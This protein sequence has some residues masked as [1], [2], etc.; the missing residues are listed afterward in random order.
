M[1]DLKADNLN[2]LKNFMKV[3]KQFTEYIKAG[4]D[5]KDLSLQKFMN[6]NTDLFEEIGIKKEVIDESLEKKVKDPKSE[7]RAPTIDD[8]SGVGL[9]EPVS[10]SEPGTAS[11]LAE[12]GT[13]K[14]SS[15]ETTIPKEN[16]IEEYSEAHIKPLLKVFS[17][18][19]EYTQNKVYQKF[20]NDFNNS[21]ISAKMFS[22]GVSTG[23]WA[24]LA[25]LLKEYNLDKYSEDM[26]VSNF[27]SVSKN[28]FN[29]DAESEPIFIEK[30]DELQQYLTSYAKDNYTLKYIV[31]ENK[32]KVVQ[33]SIGGFT[34]MSNIKNQHTKTKD[35]KFYLLYVADSAIQQSKIE[36][37]FQKREKIIQ[38]L[39]TSSFNKDVVRNNETIKENENVLASSIKTIKPSKETEK[40][41]TPIQKPRTFENRKENNVLEITRDD[42][43]CSTYSHDDTENAC[44]KQDDNTYSWLSA[45]LYAF[46]AHKETTD[47]IKDKKD[48]PSFISRLNNFYEKNNE[49]GWNTTTYEELK[50]NLK[51]NNCKEAILALQDY[52]GKND[53]SV[54][55]VVSTNIERISNDQVDGQ[56]LKC[57]VVKKDTNQYVTYAKKP[58]R[59]N[60]VEF[61]DNKTTDNEIILDNIKNN[62]ENTFFYLLYVGKKPTST[63]TEESRMLHKFAP[64]TTTGHG[65]KPRIRKSVKAKN[66]SP[67][68]NRNARSRKNILRSFSPKKRK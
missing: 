6:K 60:Y 56:D 54:I 42:S 8:G 33:Y 27:I 1:E 18:M 17:S 28:Y 43:P 19:K 20:L 36:N 67:L 25:D 41:V 52:F 23:V 37:S 29:S 38:P 62:R 11:D 39:S 65:R 51:L 57:I 14:S 16:K 45:P 55:G 21:Y 3:K 22:T 49:T 64:G 4:T 59:N 61:S 66:R 5:M 68:K 2:D 35:E 7:T 15:S 31:V 30:I 26:P 10:S 53:V 24:K 9:G 32:V 58:E 48:N 34:N 46:L 40:V 50:T 47:L 63:L 12:S 44:R 13:P